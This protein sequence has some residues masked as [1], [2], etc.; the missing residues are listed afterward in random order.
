VDWRSERPRRRPRRTAASGAYGFLRPPRRH[1]EELQQV[2]AH[3]RRDPALLRAHR[4]SLLVQAIV[5]GSLFVACIALAV[6]S[7][8]LL[9]RI[10]SPGMES[11][12]W[13]LPALVGA[14][15]LLVLRRLRRIV[16]DYKRTRLE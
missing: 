3:G 5:V 11:V 2:L 6:Q 7:L 14:F 9:R 8:L 4:T 1:E 12:G 13:M 10:R 15:A 16:S